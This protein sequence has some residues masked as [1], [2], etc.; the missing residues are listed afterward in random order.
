MFSKVSALS[1]GWGFFFFVGLLSSLNIYVWNVS[2]LHSISMHHYLCSNVFQGIDSSIWSIFLPFE[3]SMSRTPCMHLFIDFHHDV[4][5]WIG[6]VSFILGMH[7]VSC[8]YYVSYFSLPQIM[9]L[10]Q[11][12]R[13]NLEDDCTWLC[14]SNHLSIHEWISCSNLVIIANIYMINICWSP[15]FFSYR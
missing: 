5:F 1:V 9:W 15:L 12:Y 14:S 7:Q 3:M 4:F 13:P 10:Y 11:L 6:S 2:Y 8:W